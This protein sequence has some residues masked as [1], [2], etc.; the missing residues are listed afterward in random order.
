MHSQARDAIADCDRRTPVVGTGGRPMVADSWRR[1]LAAGVDPAMRSAPMVFD[2]D[3]VDGVRQSH[4]LDR[5]LPMLR[6]T[7]RGM[8][9]ASAHLMVVTDA[10]GHVLWSEGPRGVRRRADD[11]GLA[12]GF[13]WAE[14]T[15]GTNGIGTALSVGGPVYIQSTEHLVSALHPWSCVAAPIT[16][17]DTGRVIGC[18][19]IS[20]TKNTMH[21]AVIALVQA[22]ARL[23]EAQL[24]LEMHRRDAHLRDRYLRHLHGDARVLVTATG[25]VLAADPDGWC[26]GRLAVP[27]PGRQVSLPDGR[28]AV[29]EV[30]G[31]AFVLRAVEG[32]RPS[33]LLRLLGDQQPCAFLDGR[34]IPLSLRHAELLALLALHPRGLTCEQS[35]FHLYGDEGNPVTVRAEIHRLRAQLG[36][37]VRAKPYRLDCDV[38]ADFLAVRRLLGAGNVA[39][40]VRLYAGPLLPR[41]ESVAIRGERADL[42]AILRR[43]LL[44]HGDIDDLWAYTQTGDDD[45]EILGRLT[46]VLPPGDPRRVTAQLREHRVLRDG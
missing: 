22:A 10:E 6:E 11:I 35:S 18:V 8:A 28:T 26:D 2:A 41:S 13:R 15:I 3:A 7:L 31:Q 19:D 30:L 37:V 4:P 36:D 45:L 25:R 9:D 42:D 17:P 12:A 46:A 20:G 27:E 33:L 29:A 23:T 38:D 21:P 1:S 32:D 24:S 14:E 43:Q 34:H 16:D 44:H 40:A 5:Q 39:G